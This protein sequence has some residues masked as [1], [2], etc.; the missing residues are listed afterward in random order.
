MERL[1]GIE[2]KELFYRRNVPILSQGSSVEG[3]QTGLTR[4]RTGYVIRLNHSTGCER[5]LG[6][7]VTTFSS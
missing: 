5:F 4:V 1:S 7:K 6:E 3:V 2:E